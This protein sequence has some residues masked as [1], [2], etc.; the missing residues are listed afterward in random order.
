MP[1][2]GQEKFEKLH[3]VGLNPLQTPSVLLFSSVLG[4][5]LTH[6]T[7]RISI[8]YMFTKPKRGGLPSSPAASAE[9]DEA[10]VKGLR[11]RKGKCYLEGAASSWQ[12]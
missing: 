3:K 7:T 5:A 8:R 10:V 11:W 6:C 2:C 9:E 4:R 12:C 1:W